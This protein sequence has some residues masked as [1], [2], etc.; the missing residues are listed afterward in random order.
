LFF[1]D[2]DTVVV[3]IDLNRDIKRVRVKQPLIRL[4][5]IANPPTYCRSPSGRSIS[6]LRSLSLGRTAA[7]PS[8]VASQQAAVMV[9]HDEGVG[10]DSLPVKK[11]TDE[12]HPMKTG[13]EHVGAVHVA[14]ANGCGV[15][16]CHG[17][18]EALPLPSKQAVAQPIF[19]N[20]MLPP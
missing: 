7:V 9:R 5:D 1:P 2:G 17:S 16:R 13:E 15:T 18:G 11:H 10:I 4:A 8:P 20:R 12:H 3:A 19:H 6:C 14:S